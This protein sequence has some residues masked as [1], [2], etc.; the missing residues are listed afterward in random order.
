MLPQVSGIEGSFKNTCEITMRVLRDN[1]TAIAA[2]LEAFV[3]D[4]LISWRL[5][6]TERAEAQPDPDTGENSERVPGA[7]LGNPNRR[8]AANENEI[9]DGA[10]LALCN[11]VTVL[12]G[13]TFSFIR[14]R[15]W[16]CWARPTGSTQ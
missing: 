16:G 11:I 14:C 10:V 2:L 15:R 8:R 4:P 6:Q 13:S 9:F 12:M 7:D 1:D 5:Q 3:Y